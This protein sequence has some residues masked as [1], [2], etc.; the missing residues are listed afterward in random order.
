MKPLD[1][2]AE[3]VAR[4]DGKFPI[5][6]FLARQEA[7]P[8]RQARSEA[9]FHAL[10]Q[11]GRRALDGGSLEKIS[12]SEVCRAAGTS[13][14]A[15]YGRFEN[16]DVFFSA[17]QRSALADVWDGIQQMLRELDA[18]DAP[19]AEFLESIAAF[20]VR[21]YRENRGLYL[22]AFKHAS[23]RPGAWTPFKKLGWS[24]SALIARTLANRL[25][26]SHDDL[27]VRQAMQFVNGLLVNATIND[28]GPIHLDDPEMVA[29]VSRF[30]C[31]YLEVPVQVP[32]GSGRSRAVRKARQ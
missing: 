29:H 7:T 12:I 13:V 25:P 11:A 3:P 22:A 24:G 16:K 15:F 21:I 6:D 9:T 28:P 30:L 2:D 20:W 19:A 8:A 1:D 26:G 5:D 23:T 14:G 18:R 4:D 10:I 17:I 27:P 32:G 31:L